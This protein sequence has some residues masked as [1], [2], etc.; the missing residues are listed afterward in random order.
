M[1][2]LS[3]IP[4]DELLPPK[5]PI[6]LA[7]MS[8]SSAKDADSAAKEARWEANRE[9]HAALSHI[10]TPK[11]R[12][13]ELDDQESRRYDMTGLADYARL[14]G[15]TSDRVA[16][17]SIKG[18]DRVQLD[19]D[20]ILKDHPVNYDLDEVTTL[21]ESTLKAI[22]PTTSY[23]ATVQLNKRITPETH[24]QDVRDLVLKITHPRGKLPNIWPGD[25]VSIYPKN[26][27]D[28]VNSLIKM[29][30][31]ENVAD[32]PI[33]WD[34]GFG[35]AIRHPCNISL[36]ANTTLRDLLVHNLDINAIP[37]RT[38]LKQL[39]RHTQDDREKERL[40]ELTQDTNTQEFYDYTSRPRRTIL[41]VLEDF[42]GV[43]IP[44]TYVLDIFPVIRGRA[45]SI[46]NNYSGHYEDRARFH[47][48]QLIVALV[49]YKTIIRKPRQV[50]LLHF[51][52]PFQI[53]GLMLTCVGAMLKIH[54][55][56]ANRSRAGC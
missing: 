49:E 34:T 19:R 30:S 31:W 15:A 7:E 28:D 38:F 10:K 3:V 39:Q 44:F 6:T 25:V 55:V 18:V 5:Y 56:G 54:Q 53:P 4:D 20:N 48:V 47:M 45:Y 26:F 16:G 1:A 2:N 43:K 51:P 24:W 17:S 12:N 11:T 46:A 35:G 13:E 21:P 37:N 29:M 36:V 33:Q 32:R 9:K 40:S 41:E 27:S 50:P 22:V 8:G 42:P 52:L 23:I 14:S